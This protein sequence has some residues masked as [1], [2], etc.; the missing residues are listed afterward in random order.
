MNSPIFYN[1]NPSKSPS[2][3][4]TGPLVPALP[5]SNAYSILC[6]DS[7]EV[8]QIRPKMESFKFSP[9][10][11]TNLNMPIQHKLPDAA[12]LRLP[13]VPYKG[14]NCFNRLAN[15]HH[16]FLVTSPSAPKISCFVQLLELLSPC[17]MGYCPI[18]KSLNKANKIF[19]F[20]SIELCSLTIAYE[21]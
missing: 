5:H 21:I 4:I 3:F 19:T 13:V 15:A 12:A 6:Q 16:C 10:S 1:K 20:H 14:T 8:T 18:H 7:V 17:W 11:A 2:I 9:M